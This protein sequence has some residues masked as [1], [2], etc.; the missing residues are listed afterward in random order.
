[1]KVLTQRHTN[2]QIKFNEDLHDVIDRIN[3]VLFYMSKNLKP[4]FKFKF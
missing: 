1:M 3:N 2:E 4:D